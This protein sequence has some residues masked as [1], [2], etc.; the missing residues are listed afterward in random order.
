[1]APNADTP[2]DPP[3]CWK[4]SRELLATPISRTATLFC[5]S[6]VVIC[7]RKPMPSPS[8][9]MNSPAVT[10]LV[11]T[12]SMESRN[13]PT[14][15]PPAPRIGRALYRPVRVGSW[16]AI[17]DVIITPTIIGVSSRPLMVGEAPCTVCW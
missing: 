12:P 10:R 8:T 1:M 14:V 15:M 13:M 4:N 3:I 16:P 17:S 9:T 2:I 5:A 6:R 11:F 7:M